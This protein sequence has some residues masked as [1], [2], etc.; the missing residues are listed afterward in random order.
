MN[1]IIALDIGEVCVDLRHHL[2]FE[3]LG[4]DQNSAIPEEF[5]LATKELEC[6]NKKESEWLNVFQNVT[7]NRFSDKELLDCWNLI[8]GPP[9]KGMHDAILEIIELGFRFI[10]FSDTSA[11]HILYTSDSLPFANLVT[12]AIYSY[13]VGVQKPNSRMYEAFEKDFGVPFFYID[14]KL[15]NIEAARR[16]GWKS[17]Q[18][19]NAIKF[20]TEFYKAIEL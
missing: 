11:G 19:E 6:G 13:E 14:D 18:F 16:R 15:E 20:K 10:F 1:K 17:H 12:G 7:N 5:L 3:C 2:C 8:I 9:K 4:L